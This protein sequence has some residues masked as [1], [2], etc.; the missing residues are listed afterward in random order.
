MEED[1]IEKKARMNKTLLNAN[2]GEFLAEK[3][4]EIKE[5]VLKFPKLKK[6]CEEGVLNEPK[7]DGLSSAQIMS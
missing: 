6:K 4:E 5:I 1:D 2:I 7:H 3:R